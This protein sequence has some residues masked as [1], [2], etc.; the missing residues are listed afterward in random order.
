MKIIIVDDEMNALQAFLS[1]IIGKR[2]IEYRFFVDEPE[3]ILDYVQ[4]NS[5]DAAFL[6]IRMPNMDGKLLAEKILAIKPNMKI[7]F[8]TGLNQKKEGL[9]PFL[10]QRVL[11]IIYK[12][13]SLDELEDVLNLLEQKKPRLIVKTMPS[14]DC[15]INDHLIRFNSSKAKELFALLIVFRGQSI[16][17]SQAITYL[18]PEK[19][20]EKA[21]I[22][23]RDAVWRLRNLLREIHFECVDFSRALLSLNPNDI[24][25]DFYEIIQGKRQYQGEPFLM[26]Y[27]WAIEFEGLLNR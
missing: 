14:F 5:V 22:L 4:Y 6:D 13:Y 11:K 18:W 15:F 25:C 24:D 1:R 9:S 16:T 8:I 20:V 10:Q 12:P 7:V 3:A 2:D 21:K 26:S 17:M 23:Y 27:D 19:E